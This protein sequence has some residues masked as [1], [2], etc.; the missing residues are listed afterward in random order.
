[1]DLQ[2]LLPAPDE[3]AGLIVMGGPMGVYE[4][5]QYPFLHDVCR[6]IADVVRRKRPVLG[7]CLG[8]QL[9]AS[10]LGG[11]VYKGPAQ[12]IG[13]GSVELT[14]EAGQDPI[15]RAL[16]GSIPVFHWH[17][18]TFDLPE[19][20]LLLAKNANYEHQAFRF[21]ENAYGLQFH[22][23]VDLGTWKEWEPRLPGY[24]AA[25]EQQIAQIGE[26]GKRLIAGFFDLALSAPSRTGDATCAG[27]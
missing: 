21:G 1:M 14:A 16:S 7:V 18:D 12:E 3:V 27:S 6:L 9:L 13:F 26:S 25:T 5:D 4:A 24:A 22:V 2:F 19:N 10:A 23:E 17:G 20:A 8:A 11:R 15:F